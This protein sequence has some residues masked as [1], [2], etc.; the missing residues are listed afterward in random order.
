[1][2]L[3]Q[4]VKVLLKRKGGPIIPGGVP[5]GVFDI[6]TQCVYIMQVR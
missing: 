5:G 2:S 4:G 6:H 3:A 1:L